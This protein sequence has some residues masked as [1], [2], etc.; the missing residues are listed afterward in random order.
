MDE[1]VT[2]YKYIPKH[3]APFAELTDFWH[4]IA[5]QYEYQHYVK[6]LL[7]QPVVWNMIVNGGWDFCL[8][9]NEW[10]VSDDS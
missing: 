1:A 6:Y 8:Y 7:S 9:S 5:I 2:S 3:T 4:N 10:N